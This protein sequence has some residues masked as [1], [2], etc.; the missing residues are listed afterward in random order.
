MAGDFNT[1]FNSDFSRVPYVVA[2]SAPI[3][4]GAA[5]I[6]R[7]GVAAALA[8]EIALNS[9]FRLALPVRLTLNASV[10]IRA[11]MRVRQLRRAKSR[12]PGAGRRAPLRFPVPPVPELSKPYQPPAKLAIAASITLKARIIIAHFGSLST[13]LPAPAPAPPAALISGRLLAG[14]SLRAHVA[15]HIPFVDGDD[16]ELIFMLAAVA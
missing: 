8:A 15:V 12:P 13:G 16:E 7:H 14:L 5:I 1:D 3:R 9:E 6:A 10:Q 2:L 11:A 4:F